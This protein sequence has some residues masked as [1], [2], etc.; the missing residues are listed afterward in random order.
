MIQ[1]SSMQ[2]ECRMQQ[3]IFYIVVA[4]C[5]AQK[6]GERRGKLSPFEVLTDCMAQTSDERW[7]ELSPHG[8]STTTR[9]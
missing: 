6:P 7:V 5:I 3:S 1:I 4:E 8:G 2:G 9:L